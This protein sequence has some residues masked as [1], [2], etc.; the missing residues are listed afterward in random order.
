MTSEVKLLL[1]DL[2]GT[3]REPILGNKFI[4][5]PRDQKLIDGVEEAL[6]R[7]E[8]WKIVGVTNQGGVAA[9]HKT[10]DEARIEQEVTLE[11]IPQLKCIYFCPDYEGELCYKVGRGTIAGYK[12]SQFPNLVVSGELLYQSFRKPGSGM[13]MLAIDQA[14]AF[15]G[16]YLMVGDRP[17]DEAA[18]LAANVPFIWA[19][20]WRGDK[21]V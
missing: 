1:L 18:A 2:D 12:R 9:G 4:S 8:D 5:S 6:S 14:N 13:L 19:H 21:N 20:D 10:L 15:S 7:Y 3:V 11:L 16:E 17:E